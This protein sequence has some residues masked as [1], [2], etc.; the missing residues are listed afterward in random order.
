MLDMG[1]NIGSFALLAGHAR[2]I[3]CV[4]HEVPESIEKISTDSTLGSSRRRRQG[5]PSSAS[6]TRWFKAAHLVEDAPPGFHPF[7]FA[8]K[9]LDIFK[10]MC[11]VQSDLAV[12]D[13][14]EKVF[15]CVGIKHLFLERPGAP[16]R[17]KP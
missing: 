3:A 4:K 5:G 17:D 10:S 2:S 15:S 9:N 12:D 1:S 6:E 14:T 13:A 7:V 16:S 8:F 11:Y